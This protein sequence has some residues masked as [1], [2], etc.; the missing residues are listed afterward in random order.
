[1][2]GGLWSTSA[3][4]CFLFESFGREWLELGSSLVTT[5]RENMEDFECRGRR[6]FSSIT[7]EAANW[8]HNASRSMAE[9]GGG[10]GEVSGVRSHPTG[11]T[12]ERGRREG[13]YV[14]GNAWA[15][16]VVVERGHF[17]YQTVS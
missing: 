9:V 6:G 14:V 10:V 4:D 3:L 11:E 15:G 1:M 5:G 2:V 7:R 12:P 8:S 16:L 13:G 17:F